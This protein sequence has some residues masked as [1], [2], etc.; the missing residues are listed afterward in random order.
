MG[1]HDGLISLCAEVS[2]GTDNYSG[3]AIT[4]DRQVVCHDASPT[5]FKTVF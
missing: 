3:S 4:P 1:P 2:P 5:R